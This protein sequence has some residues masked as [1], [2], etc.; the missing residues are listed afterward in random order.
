MLTQLLHAPWEYLLQGRDRDLLPAAAANCAPVASECQPGNA[1]YCCSKSHLHGQLGGPQVSTV[2]VLLSSLSLL[3]AVEAHKAKLARAAVTAQVRSCQDC[4]EA[5]RQL[6][7]Y[8]I[9]SSELQAAVSS[10]CLAPE[11]T[12]LV[13][14]TLASVTR[15]FS[16]NSLRRVSSVVCLASP[17]THSL[18]VAIKVGC[19]RISL[20]ETASVYASGQEA[21][22]DEC[23]SAAAS[24]YCQCAQSRRQHSLHRLFEQGQ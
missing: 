5:S 14:A 11:H 4:A 21:Q 19:H 22:H 18:D 16:E 13:R 3:N 20:A 8:C 17:F 6:P 23:C 2:E 24:K 7:E 10:A 12:D 9:A 1:T 15:P